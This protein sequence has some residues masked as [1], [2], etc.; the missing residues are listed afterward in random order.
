MKPHP[1]HLRA[2]LQLV[3]VAAGEAVMV[4]DSVRQDVDGAL[5]APACA[6]FCCTAA[7]GR[8]PDAL[9]LSARGVP[10][11]RSLRGASGAL[12]V[13]AEITSTI[14]RAPMNRIYPGGHVM[15]R[16]PSRCRWM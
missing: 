3:D 4:G 9:E 12:I 5:A 10:V 14:S 15:L 2:A 7:R 1:E 13:T 8:H 16:P 6:P 11:I